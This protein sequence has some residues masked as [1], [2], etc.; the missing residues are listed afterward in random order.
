MRPIT[1]L[2]SNQVISTRIFPN[3]KKHFGLL[4]NYLETSPG[5]GNY[6]CGQH[7]TGADIIIAYPLMTGKDGL[8]D[9]AGTYDKGTFKET[10]PKLHAYSQ[11]LSGET[12][13][14]KTMQ[15]IEE[16]EGSFSLRP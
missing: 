11:R 3:L 14:K 10:Y 9:G 15:K 7:L 8:F 13:W 12:G 16:A 5:G 6:L 2:V 1:R 4:E